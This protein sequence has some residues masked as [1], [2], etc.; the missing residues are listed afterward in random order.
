MTRHIQYSVI[1]SFIICLTI[2]APIRALS[3]DETLCSVGPSLHL[4]ENF[5]TTALIISSQNYDKDSLA[6]ILIPVLSD[7]NTPQI[8]VFDRDGKT[9][10][11]QENLGSPFR[12]KWSEHVT[13]FQDAVVWSQDFIESFNDKNGSAFIR[14]VNGYKKNDSHFNEYTNA[15]AHL[16]EKLKS[17]GISIRQPI[18]PGDLPAKNGHKGGNIESTNEGFCLIGNADLTA[19]EWNELA[20]QN[21]GGPENTVRLQTDWLPAKHVDELIKQLPNMSRNSCDATFALSSPQKALEL[22]ESQPEDLFFDSGIVTLNTKMYDRSALGQICAN[23]MHA[24]FPQ[25][26]GADHLRPQSNYEPIYP[27]QG[28]VEYRLPFANETNTALYGQCFK[29]KNKDVVNLFKSDEKL[30]YSLSYSQKITN[31]SKKAIVSFYT[32]KRPD[33]K[34]TF[35]EMPTLFSI[36]TSRYYNEDRSY[37][38]DVTNSEALLPNPINNLKVG[39]NIFIP[40]SANKSVNKYVEEVYKRYGLNPTFLNTFDLHINQGNIHCSSQTVH[41]CKKTTTKRNPSAEPSCGWEN[42]NQLMAS[43]K[44]IIEKFK[45]AD[46]NSLFNLTGHKFESELQKQLTFQYYSILGEA[47]KKKTLNYENELTLIKESFNEVISNPIARP[48]L[49]KVLIDFDVTAKS[50]ASAHPGSPASIVINPNIIKEIFNNIPTEMQGSA[51]NFIV[52]HEVGHLIVE[53]VRTNEM[54]SFEKANTEEFYG[55]PKHHL[56]VDAVGMYLASSN[57]EETLKILKYFP[58]EGDFSDRI[59]CLEHL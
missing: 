14:L 44:E 8:I 7:K 2:F 11:L 48:L 47:L 33:C 49:N 39:R 59:Y 54:G 17:L 23:I 22:L 3:Q 32:K 15:Q 6:K 34:V 58:N 43:A 50:V 4:N 28:Y 5:N 18:N 19:N 40:N 56:L 29:I 55:K 30:K 9:D 20:T 46:F 57:W 12:A 24:Q 13:V 53:S 16:I 35:V 51:I 25:D 41:S 26:I 1:L 37:N 27:T 45:H 36:D 42:R 38:I 52:A 31:E 21:C 10:S